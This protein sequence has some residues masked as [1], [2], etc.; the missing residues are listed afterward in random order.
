VSTRQ[1]IITLLKAQ[2]NP[3]VLLLGDDVASFDVVDYTSPA[4]FLKAYL[5]NRKVQVLFT[6]KR[7]N[8]LTSRFLQHVPHKSKV[9]FIIGVWCASKAPQQNTN[10][11]NLRDVAVSEVERVFK[12]FPAYGSETSVR[13]DDHTKGNIQIYNT[14]IVVTHIE[15]S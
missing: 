3:A 9:G 4:Y 12:A 14:E 2:L 13:D 15:N 10:Y 6:L 11:Q 5:E 7:A 8:G 1:D